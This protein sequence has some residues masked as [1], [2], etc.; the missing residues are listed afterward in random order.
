M[1]IHIS[2]VRGLTTLP[3]ALQHK[4]N[5]L[6]VGY[7][8]ACEAENLTPIDHPELKTVILRVW[9]YSEFVATLCVR[10][11]EIIND[12]VRSGDLFI[13][14]LPSGYNKRIYL[15]LEAVGEFSSLSDALRL[16]RK[17]EMLRIAFRDLAGWAGL[18]ETLG[19][20]SRFAD[21]CVQH[22]NNKLHTWLCQS[23]GEPLGEESKKPQRLVVLGMGKLGAYEL[24]FSSDIDLIFAYP[25]EGETSGERAISNSEFFVKLGRQLIRALDETTALG[26]VFRVDMRLRPFGESGPL[27]MGFEAMEGYYQT[28]GRDWERYAMIKARPLAGDVAAGEQL[29]EILRPFIY[30][31]YLDFGA[32]EAIRDMKAM[33]TQQVRRK[34]MED[35]VK[36]GAG[37]IRE[38]EF[39]G[40]VF[41]LIRGGRER[42]LQVQPILDVLALLEK[43]DYLPSYV[44]ESLDVAYYFLRHTENRLQAY[45]DQQTHELPGQAAM[46]DALR[47]SMGFGNWSDFLDQLKA[48]MTTVHDHFEQVFTAPQAE[49]Q[50]CDAQTGLHALWQGLW[51]EAQSAEY[52][53]AMGFADGA[54]VNHLLSQLR[55][56]SSYRAMTKNGRDR[57]DVLMPMVL[58]AAVVMADPMATVARL[59]RII[60]AVGR[61]S[62]YLALLVEYPM[63]LSQLAKLSHASSWVSDFISKHP[64]VMDELLNPRV[65]YAPLTH[66]ALA[67]E[68]HNQLK[69]IDAD[70]LEQQMEI[71]R[72]FKQS[73]VLRVAAADVSNA[74]P[75]MV[76]S[77]YLTE[78]SEVI[79]TRVLAQVWDA[80][81]AKH[82]RPAVSSVGGPTPG[83]AIVAY[84]KMGG[85][86][87]GYGSDLDLVFIYDTTAEEGYTLGDKPISNEVFFTRLGQRI[88]HMLSARTPSGVLYEVDMRLRPSG[89]SGLLVTSL[90]AY[91]TYLQEDAW[92]WEHQALV[93]ARFVAGDAQLA[94]GF[95]EVR[96]LVLSCSRP[97]EGLQVEVREMRE[98]MRK[99]LGSKTPG[100]CD[101]KQDPGGIADIEF[102]V[103]YC[104]LRWSND[105]PVL[106]QRTDNIRILACLGAIGVLSEHDAALLADAYKAYRAEVHRLTL[107][108]LPAEVEV[109]SFSEYRQGVVEIWRKLMENS[110]N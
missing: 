1:T 66:D 62:A 74:I 102:I 91:Q 28:H 32:F 7:C 87:L 82:G 10:S 41:Q 86:E 98:R 6:W 57:M 68:L 73:N 39:I 72:H 29:L 51:P 27:A 4:V 107:Q 9:A 56:G 17:R 103:Q 110:P 59:I 26:N 45:N 79:L 65:L 63:A 46:K 64:L 48:H 2:R 33:I 106:T 85:I 38:V 84:G 101:L 80:L 90:Q 83:F 50:V 94:E 89:A 21:A 23:Y 44:V 43:K 12:L 37:G 69:G 40:Q 25:E 76:V 88:I 55:E 97:L 34:G 100:I 36:L 18:L 77:D 60:E 35:N 49:S 104:V 95:K 75:L 13:D 105:Y 96:S 47:A 16:Q 30:R 8:S 61:R 109:G 14:Y 20:L 53:S 78:I 15:A 71:L 70:D 3:E 108:D 42:D 22:A 54:E 19:D 11:P 52:L 31:R 67:Q 81:V 99:E 58:G 24:N 5:D 92:T 93:R